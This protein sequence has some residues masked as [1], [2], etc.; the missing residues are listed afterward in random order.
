MEQTAKL[1]AL[2]NLSCKS[3]SLKMVTTAALKNRI[4]VDVSM[5]P[6]LLFSVCL[7]LCGFAAS[8]ISKADFAADS[9]ILSFFKGMDDVNWDSLLLGGMSFNFFL[10]VWYLGRIYARREE[11]RKGMGGMAGTMQTISIVARSS[12][13][14]FANSVQ[15]WRYM[16]CVNVFA[17]S[18]IG[19]GSI[20]SNSNFAE[21]M[22]NLWHLLTPQEMEMLEVLRP[23]T[24][25]AHKEFCVYCAEVCTNSLQHGEL[26]PRTY[27]RLISLIC[28]LR[29]M[30]SGPN[31]IH[32]REPP[33]AVRQMASFAVFFYVSF[34]AFCKGV[35]A[36]AEMILT[37]PSLERGTSTEYYTPC[38]D[39]PDF[40]DEWAG[41]RATSATYN[42]GT[43]VAWGGDG[44]GL[45]KTSSATYSYSDG[46]CTGVTVTTS[47]EDYSVYWF[48]IFMAFFQYFIV[49][50]LYIGL[51]DLCDALRDCY[52]KGPL[53]IDMA[54]KVNG[55]IKLTR[56]IVFFDEVFRFFPEQNRLG[57]DAI[58]DEVLDQMYAKGVLDPA[59]NEHKWRL[60]SNENKWR[61]TALHAL[62]KKFETVG[63]EGVK[64]IFEAADKDGSG[65]LE[66][67]EIGQ[68]FRQED[69]NFP[70]DQ[71]F[72]IMQKL[73]PDRSGAVTWDEFYHVV[74]SGSIVNEFT[75]MFHNSDEQISFETMKAQTDV[76]ASNVPQ[77]AGSS[78]RKGSVFGSGAKIMNSATTDGMN[79]FGAFSQTAA[80]RLK[81]YEKKEKDSS[82]KQ[83]DLFSFANRM[84]H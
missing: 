52:G 57:K 49:S 13:M 62:T 26:D 14:S 7:F 69:P 37:T 6:M 70:E 46:T 3:T 31:T 2:D 11:A 25:Y 18:G 67:A 1:N 82:Q 66:V 23:N 65:E 44:R 28:T 43:S 10:L 15:L 22:I 27:D 56:L 80:Q 64:T 68:I 45:G 53:S 5:C 35:N 40:N 58:G 20:Y 41:S 76:A 60:D 32:G 48:S 55:N 59:A 29:S 75:N 77:D 4:F 9:I 30:A 36:G 12:G 83:S 73:D 74:C 24:S 42:L 81:E 33:F 71:L 63:I 72:E 47:F 39:F 17:V 8:C 34:L 19:S 78:R 51:L 16:C 38:S 79:L 54:G 61:S 50:F 21:S 84:A